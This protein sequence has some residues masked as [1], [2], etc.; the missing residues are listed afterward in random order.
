MLYISV[1][2][3]STFIE[4]KVQEWLPGAMMREKG[5]F[6]NG[7]RVSVSKDENNYGEGRW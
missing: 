4:T 1:Y 3:T 7:F 2:I 5:K 6:F